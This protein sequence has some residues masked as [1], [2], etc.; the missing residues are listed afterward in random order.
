M[1][2]R[3]GFERFGVAGH[4]RLCR[5]RRDIVTI[6]RRAVSVGVFARCN[7]QNIMSPDYALISRHQTY[8]NAAGYMVAG[9]RK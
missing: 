3:F 1:M 4:N 6:L 8:K 2:R 9:K 5:L 7:Q